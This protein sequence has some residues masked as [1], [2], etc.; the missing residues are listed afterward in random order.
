MHLIYRVVGMQM[1]AN[2]TFV[3]RL[4]RR[5]SILFTLMGLTYGG[6]VHAEVPNGPP[7]QDAGRIM[8]F[9]DQTPLPAL[10]T[11]SSPEIDVSKQSRP[12]MKGGPSTAFLVTGFKITGNT[13]I[14]AADLQAKLNLLVGKKLNLDQL[15]EAADQ[16]SDYYRS[17]G[18]LVARAY[19]P[20]QE[21]T[22]GVVEIQIIEG[23]RGK[24]NFK[25]NGDPLVK[26]V[27]QVDFLDK[28]VGPNQVITEA[29]LERGL[30]LLQDTPGISDVKSSLEPGDTVGT[31]N[32]N[33]ETVTGPRYFSSVDADNFGSRYSGAGRVGVTLGV[34]SL[35]GYGDQLT[36]RAQTTGTSAM[37]SGAKTNYGRISYQIP[38]GSDG[39]KVGAAYSA[40]AYELGLNYQGTN[41]KGTA[42]TASLFGSYPFIRSRNFNLYGQVGFDNLQMVNNSL[43]FELSDKSLNDGSFGISGNSR[44]GFLTGGINTFGLTATLGN[45]DSSN[46]QYNA[47]DASTTKTVGTFQRYNFNF[48]RLQ[49][50]TNSTQFLFNAYGQFAS[51]NLD[52]SQQFYLGGPTG[53]RAYPMG[54]GVGSQGALIQLELQQQLL[55]D[56]YLGQ[57]SGFAFYD[58][59]TVQ[60]FKNTWLNWNPPSTTN[61]NTG[62]SMSNTTTL[63]GAGLGLKA[64]I[65]NRSYLTAT[66]A[67]AIGTS[68]SFKAYGSNSDGQNLDNTFWFQGVLQF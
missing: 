24:I 25:S 10:S 66:W 63:M 67:H 59:G 39:L 34:N 65:N 60:L 16:I 55:N 40:M 27:V 62:Y 1:L 21:I 14:P 29:D 28:A 46:A 36:L 7:P 13:V 37:Q 5:V 64:T 22:G 68:Q 50:V 15:R 51:K 11:P 23:R 61:P 33:L 48:S 19:I 8:Q 53:V 43:G 42:N 4:E 54:E 57:I 31:S 52:S 3:L 56:S 32:L 6:V 47:T 44:D 38:I 9:I 20:A 2:K 35:S 17:K 49:A 30:L 41:T 26:P 58:V 45:L 12:A 18:Y